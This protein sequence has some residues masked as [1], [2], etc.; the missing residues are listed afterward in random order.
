MTI[1]HFDNDTV[2]HLSQNQPAANAVLRQYK[3]APNSGLRLG[4]AAAAAGV[5]VDELMAQVEAAGRRSA[6]R[7][8]APV[9]E[10]VEL[11]EEEVYA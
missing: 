10:P 8:V 11:Y 9:A 2:S 1:R 4:Q 3:I 7:A 5:N 6:R